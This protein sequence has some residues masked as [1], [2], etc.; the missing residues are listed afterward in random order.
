MALSDLYS[1]TL[2]ELLAI[3][4]AMLSPDWQDALDAATKEER[5]AASHG[6][7]DVQQ[8]LLRL[9]DA[10]LST[11]AAKMDAQRGLL[12]GA[13]VEVNRTLA[14][15]TNVRGVLDAVAQMV[16]VVA[17]IVPLI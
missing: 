15:M 14:D 12:D 8:A 17:Q 9:S 4:N 10:S 11:I 5:L 7:L 2:A 3:K 13:I 6:L 1:S 16:S